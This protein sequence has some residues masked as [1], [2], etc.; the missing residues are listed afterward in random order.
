MDLYENFLRSA[1]YQK[2]SHCNGLKLFFGLCIFGD[3]LEE[4]RTKK[5]KSLELFRCKVERSRTKSFH[6]ISQLNIEKHF[7]QSNGS[8]LSIDFKESCSLK[9]NEWI[10]L[11][12]RN[13]SAQIEDSAYVKK[14]II[15]I[16]PDKHLALG[17][18]LE[19]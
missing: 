1:L 5:H 8:K 6:T 14:R 9:Q 7:S 19:V 13:Y 15:K 3:F 18:N 4:K 17:H 10:E 2:T 16:A 11:S 12:K